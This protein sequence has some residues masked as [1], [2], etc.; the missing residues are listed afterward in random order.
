MADLT[1]LL[2]GCRGCWL[3]EDDCFDN[4]IRYAEQW[5][6][7]EALQNHIRSELYRRVLGAMELS[8]SKP[9]VSFYYA[10]EKKGFELIE[11]VRPQA[12]PPYATSD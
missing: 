2:A 11:A 7:E 1:R 5:E 10:T 8:Q 12:R 6:T 3:S 4:Q 9:D